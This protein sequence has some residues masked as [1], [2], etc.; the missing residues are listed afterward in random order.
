[1]QRQ[2]TRGSTGAVNLIFH[3]NVLDSASTTGGGLTAKIF[4][5][6]TVRYIRTG[7]ALSGA[8]TPQDITTIGT[9]VAPTANTNIRIKK[10]DDTN[11]PGI[12]EVHLHQDWVNTTNS[13]QSLLIQFRV[14]GGVPTHLMIP[15]IK[16]SPSEVSE[17]DVID[18]VYAL[19]SDPATVAD[20]VWDE[21]T[22]SHTAAGSFGKLATDGVLVA[23]GGIG[24]GAHAAA[25]LN[26]IAD[27]VLDRN[28]ATGTDSGTPS[29]A[30]RTVRQS[31][32]RNRNKE[33]ILAGTLTGTKEDDSTTSWTG[34]VATSAGNPISSVDPT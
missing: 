16:A 20:A 9:W 17:Q 1:M 12:Y 10:V 27:G 33:S 34:A 5:D 6:F 2:V 29:T 23:T 31:L 22:A 3:I 28:M 19:M 7:E 25:E 24:V 26:A 21:A 8:I 18:A 32:R 4:S 13:C 30:V 15:L 11:F 14:T